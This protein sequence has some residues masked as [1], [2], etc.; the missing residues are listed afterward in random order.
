MKYDRKMAERGDWLRKK[1]I[2]KIKFLKH[3]KPVNK[4]F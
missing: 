4:A 2:L 1:N 3:T